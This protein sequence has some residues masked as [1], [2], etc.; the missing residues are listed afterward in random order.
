M[1]EYVGGKIIH[2]SKKTTIIKVE[3]M[4]ISREGE[5]N[6][7]RRRHTPGGGAG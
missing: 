7:I 2:E 5:G 6:I 3:V 4:V 1:D